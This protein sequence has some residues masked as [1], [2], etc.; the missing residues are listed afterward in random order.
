MPIPQPLNPV[1][2]SGSMTN[3]P[4]LNAGPRMNFNKT[5][6]QNLQGRM[7]FRP[8]QVQQPNFQRGSL[9]NT[10]PNIG[11]GQMNNQPYQPVKQM[12]M[13]GMLNP[14]APQMG[15]APQMPM[16]PA[17]G[18]NPSFSSPADMG[19][20]TTGM[21]IQLPSFT[22]FQEPSGAPP[23][24]PLGNPMVGAGLQPGTLSSMGPSNN[25]WQKMLQRG[26]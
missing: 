12:P 3:N 4:G 11:S 24:P 13:M 21:G 14:S 26:F 20:A 22:Q 17:L 25:I 6:Q 1:N 16:N 15:S 7:S 23:S 2:Q 10:A 8:P 19:Q 9:G 18:I 5:P